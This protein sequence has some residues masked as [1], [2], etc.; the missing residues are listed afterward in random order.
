MKKSKLFD[1][2]ANA[3]AVIVEGDAVVY[4]VITDENELSFSWDNPDGNYRYTVD[5]EDLIMTATVMN[6]SGLLSV[7][8]T[9]GIDFQHT[10]TITIQVLM[11]PAIPVLL[12]EEG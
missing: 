2:I 1:Y 6:N 10:E 12:L 7:L 4:P 5:R 8:A 9:E 3:A 11:L